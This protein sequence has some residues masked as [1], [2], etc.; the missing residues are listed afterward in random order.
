MATSTLSE[1]SSVQSFQSLQHLQQYGS[2]LPSLEPRASAL[3]SDSSFNTS[4]ILARRQKHQIQ[5]IAATF[6][7]MSVLAALCALYWFCMMRRNF[8]R[9]LVLLLIIGDFWKSLWFLV[10]SAVT[11]AGGQ[12]ATETAFCQASGYFL[13][14]GAEA[15]GE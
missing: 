15:C 10:G 9:D 5:T 12:V 8:R 14:V 4:S 11:L 3:G 6:S 2:L 13:Q 1:A 7:S